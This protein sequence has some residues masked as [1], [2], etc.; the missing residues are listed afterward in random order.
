VEKHIK[1]RH[2]RLVVVGS[3][4]SYHRGDVFE[5]SE[6]QLREGVCDLVG[7]GR[8]WLAYP[9]F[10]R[11]YLNGTFE[12]KRC[13]LTC[14]KCTELMRAGQVSGCAVFEEYYRNL[15]KEIVK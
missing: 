4:L 11:D 5:V 7:Y 6:R 12:A 10:Y 3:G 9:A 15:Y 2:P 8:L 13:C 14:S 1:Q